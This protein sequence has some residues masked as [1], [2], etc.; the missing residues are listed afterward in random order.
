MIKECA[1]FKMK[2]IKE[3]VIIGGLINSINIPL[4]ICLLDLGL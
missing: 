3:V 1:R 4:N 2:M